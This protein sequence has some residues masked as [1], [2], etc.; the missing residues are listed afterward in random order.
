MA[1]MKKIKCDGAA[2]ACANC[3]SAH[4]ACV[5]SAKLRRR[6]KI[7]GYQSSTEEQ[8][9]KLQNEIVELKH[10]LEA[11]RKRSAALQSRLDDLSKAPKGGSKP[12]NEYL[13]T[14]GSAGRH[15]SV[16]TDSH[17]T[18]LNKSALVIKHMGR[19]V[20][21]SHGE[22]RFAGSTTGVHFILSVQQA[23][24]ARHIWHTPFPESCFRLYLLDNHGS[25][26]DHLNN[27]LLNSEGVLVSFLQYTQRYFSRPPSFY[28]KQVIIHGLPTLINDADVD[29]DYPVDCELDEADA[30]S[31]SLPLPGETTKVSE[32]IAYAQLARILSEA[33][34]ELYT[35]TRRRGGAEK[36]LKLHNDLQVWEQRFKQLLEESTHEGHTHS[37]LCQWLS[38]MRDVTMVQIHRPALTF[39]VTTQQF[40]ESLHACAR[41]SSAI[42]E[43]LS[44]H[45]GRTSILGMAPAGPSLISQC[46][47]TH[48]LYQTQQLDEEH[49]GDRIFLEYSVEIIEQA[50][51]LLS[52]YK[53]RPAS[54]LARPRP[55]VEPLPSGL[56]EVSHLLKSLCFELKKMGHASTEPEAMHDVAQTP[57]SFFDSHLL[58]QPDAQTASFD[59]LGD[60]G[61]LDMARTK[62]FMGLTGRAL[63]LA[64]MATIVC[65]A[66]VLFGYNQSNLGGLVG[67]EDW[68]KHFPRIDTI[69]TK[70]AQKDNNATIQGLVVATYT[71]G[72][73]PGCLSCSYSAD[74]FGRRRI[75]FLGALLSLIGEVLEASSYRLAQLI[76]GRLI[77]GAG[78]GML[79]G[80]VPTW[81]SECSSSTNRGRHVVLDGMFISLGYVLQAWINLG[82][83]Q[84]KLGPI[85]WRPPISIATFF[86][87]VLMACIF[88]MPESP[89]W[90]LRRNRVEEA[91]MS[92][93]ALKGLPPDAPEIRAEIAAIEISL[94]ENAGKSASL[95]QLLTMGKDKLLYRFGIC[96]LL[97]FYQQMAG[98][99]LI[100]VYSTIIFQQGLG[101]DAQTAR[102]LSGGTLTW[103]FLSCFVS[104]LTIDRFGRRPALM[105]SGAGMASCMLG[106]A[107]A[108]SF[109]RSNFPAQVISVLFV[110]LFNFFIPIGFLGANFLYCTEVAPLRLRVAMS[111]I[112]TAN[113]WLWNFVV[114]MITPVA[115]NSIGY[116]YY[117]VYTLIG[118]CIP[119]SVYF[120][121]PETMGMSLEDIDLIFRNSPSVLGTVRYAKTRPHLEVDAALEEVLET[122]PKSL[123]ATRPDV[124]QD[125]KLFTDSEVGPLSPNFSP[126][127]R[128]TRVRVANSDTIDAALSLTTQGSPDSPVC[129]LNMA[130]TIHAGG[131]FKRD[132]FAQEEALCYRSSPFFTLKT[133]FYPTPA[134]A[135][136]YSPQVLVFRESMK[137]G[138]DLMDLREPSRLPVVS[139]V[140][141]A[142]IC[143]P[144]LLKSPG[145]RQVYRTAKDKEL[146]MEK[147][148]VILR[149]ANRN[150]HRKLVLGA[151]GC[152]AFV[153]PPQE[154]AD[155][156]AGVFQEPEFQMG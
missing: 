46:G 67:L 122:K 151:F 129:A 117:I 110:F 135:A 38:F 58:P 80:T 54:I 79:S 72:A 109:P 136:I 112:S 47:L 76:I 21:D 64:Q 71:L 61:A 138:H 30:A 28:K 128:T 66:F 139:V 91:Q 141:T 142:A 102:I 33:L 144:G 96:I 118:F 83:Y 65:P 132:A 124:G 39:D 75:I 103:K 95:A 59:F 140:S 84:Y 25:S 130:S 2:P 131:G 69:H 8:V 6:T 123:L 106:L 115:I 107:V 37:I 60:L 97:Q 16:S 116:K 12:Q 19:L 148:R 89:R 108:T 156:W 13:N 17:I 29:V 143:R 14:P 120:L 31:L 74:R 104:F 137:D 7:R 20:L 77:L 134:K 45:S 5:V 111:S 149:V 34:C 23:L 100:S 93:S 125:A 18:E 119:F 152:G 26:T 92:M 48:M 88:S 98:G 127:L 63:T 24:H 101:L 133:K 154:V 52:N 49:V 105:V 62:F 36:I 114:T 43:Q 68:V 90:L 57:A 51:D 32:F 9:S 145:G 3:A 153:N 1:G 70:G 113:H 87:L 44:R 73:L 42:I 99:N 146:M 147:M 81:Q 41:A 11:E 53:A 86:S 50:V 55:L 40:T 150:R 22:E 10:A 94:E 27:L 4:A 155:M 82:F 35:T 85:T 126:K 121:Y 78:V 56:L 15:H